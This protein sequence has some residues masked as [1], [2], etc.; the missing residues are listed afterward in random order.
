MRLALTFPALFL[1]L[2]S[3]SGYAA[4]DE[5]SVPGPVPIHYKL[6]G[7][8][9]PVIFLHGA[10]GPWE[11]PTTL[12]FVAGIIPEFMLINVDIRG[13]GDSSKPVLAED[14]GLALVED[15]NRVL[16]HLDLESA[17]IVGYSM[18][19]Y[20]GLKY[21]TLYPEK[22]RSL[23]LVGAGLRRIEDFQRMEQLASEVVNSND[24]TQFQKEN[25]H[26][27]TALRPAQQELLVTEEEAR[28]LSVPILAVLGEADL[29]IAEARRLEDEYPQTRM[30][31][32]V[33]YGHNDIL[34]H[35]APTHFLLSGF[36]RDMENS[37]GP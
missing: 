22:V 33:G 7:E 36:L 29:A 11:R 26:L 35:G 4:I 31:I 37:D 19:G 13:Y 27:F 5:G 12:D 14:Y 30:V 9:V 32:A 15:I 24:K 21:A 2:F 28:R 23:T 3:L 10:G 20:I 8:G 34:D 16:T 18:G 17:H 1:L 6:I 25:L